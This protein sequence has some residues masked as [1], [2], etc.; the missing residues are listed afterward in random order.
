[1]LH[2]KQ[3]F[4][5]DLVKTLDT[6]YYPTVKYYRDNENCA[7]MHYIVELFNNGCLT[8]KDLINKLAKN[9]NDKNINLHTIVSNFII[10]F[11]SYKPIFKK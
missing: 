5:N 7:K 9:C 6:K 1:M 11:G 2:T 4:Y 3:N 8:Y 10:S